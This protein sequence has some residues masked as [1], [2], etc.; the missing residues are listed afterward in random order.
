MA[1]VR[2]RFIMVSNRLVDKT[3][4]FAMD[5][6]KELE[7][8]NVELNKFK[9]VC[10]TLIKYRVSDSEY[11]KLYSGIDRHHTYPLSQHIDMGKIKLNEAL[12]L[13]S[14]I[15]ASYSDYKPFTKKWIFRIPT[16]MDENLKELL[17]GVLDRYTHILN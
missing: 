3:N 1:S 13:V 12:D 16:P 10:E 15:E 7:A 4:Y 17:N 8:C 14:V 2:E 9:S 6:D 5:L 11:M